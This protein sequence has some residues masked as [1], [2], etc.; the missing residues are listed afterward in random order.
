MQLN[1]VAHYISRIKSKVEYIKY[2]ITH[3]VFSEI[4][5]VADKVCKK[6]LEYVEEDKKEDEVYKTSSNAILVVV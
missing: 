3:S 4:A 5:I 1:N 2:A 6:Q